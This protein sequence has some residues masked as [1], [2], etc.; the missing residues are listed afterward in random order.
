MTLGHHIFFSGG[1]TS[2]LPAID[3]E[4]VWNSIIDDQKS[5]RTMILHNIDPLTGGA[6]LRFGDWKLL[7]S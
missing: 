1:N 7:Y 4:D 6:G 5:P 3:G 2:H